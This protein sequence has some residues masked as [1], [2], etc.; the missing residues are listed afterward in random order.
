[1]KSRLGICKRYHGFAIKKYIR[2][3]EGFFDIV[4][5]EWGMEFEM[6]HHGIS[7]PIAIHWVTH[8]GLSKEKKVIISILFF[9]VEVYH[10]KYV[11]GIEV[12]G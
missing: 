4:Q 7:L 9:I 12:L 5:R 8:N 2:L 3:S 1:M 10:R 11:N 6:L